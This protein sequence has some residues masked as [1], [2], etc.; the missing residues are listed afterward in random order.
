MLRE[1]FHFLYVVTNE[2]REVHHSHPGKVHE[3]PDVIG[4]KARKHPLTTEILHDQFHKQRILIPQKFEWKDS[5]EL[6]QTTV[7][8]V[9]LIIM[10]IQL[11][12][13][14]SLFSNLWYACCH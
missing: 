7:F 12:L 8:D 6:A 11:L 1:I 2:K 13:L 9:R 5:G 14:M 4:I 10:P 3:Q